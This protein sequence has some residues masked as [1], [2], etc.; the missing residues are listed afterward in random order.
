M[1]DAEL[2]QR[3]V[4][5]HSERYGETFWEFFYSSDLP[6]MARGQQTRHTLALHDSGHTEG[7]LSI[8]PS[9]DS[10]PGTHRSRIEMHKTRSVIPDTAPLQI[11][12]KA[13]HHLEVT[14]KKAHIDGFPLDMQ[15]MLRYSRAGQAQP[16]I[17]R[18]RAIGRQHVKRAT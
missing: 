11:C 3:M 1:S 17:G 9:S 2:L 10:L 15:A 18:W 7:T 6:L 14:P 12:G 13:V 8:A 5:S 16:G 4:T